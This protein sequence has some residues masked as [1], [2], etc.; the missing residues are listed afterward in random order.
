MVKKEVVQDKGPAKTK[1]MSKVEK[2]T[3]YPQKTLFKK[4]HLVVANKE[5]TG[6]RKNSR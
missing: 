5:G 1:R 4:L 2:T 6:M 3:D